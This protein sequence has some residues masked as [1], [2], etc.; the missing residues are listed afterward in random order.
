MCM[1]DFFFIL[2]FV[3]MLLTLIALGAGLLA[4]AKGGAFNRKY[5]NRLMQA[6]VVLQGLAVGL[7]ILAV[8]STG[9][10]S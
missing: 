9:A 2:M 1:T 10:G 4:M 6:R 8:L 7:F 5:G 3:A